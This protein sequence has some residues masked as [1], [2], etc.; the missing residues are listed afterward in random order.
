MSAPPEFNNDNN[1]VESFLASA[2]PDAVPPVSDLAFSGL[3]NSAV[4]AVVGA[5]T[6]VVNGTAGNCGT[7]GTY[8]TLGGTIQLTN[9][10]DIYIAHDNGVRLLID[11]VRVPGFSDGGDSVALEAYTFTGLT[12]AHTIELIYVNTCGPGYLSF[13]PEM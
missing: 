4:G 10:Q 12:G 2:H 7:Y 1:T 11:G 9:G 5:D 3:Y 8:M 6:P 13:S